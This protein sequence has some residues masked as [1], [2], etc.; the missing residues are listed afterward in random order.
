[1]PDAGGAGWL[2][3]A[4]KAMKAFFRYMKLSQDCRCGSGRPYRACC[5][6]EELIGLV[7]AMVVLALMLSLPSEG[8]PSRII[9]S[10]V[11]LVSWICVFAMLLEWILRWRAR[12]RKDEGRA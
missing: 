11:G 12:K 9:R 2:R 3:C 8:W 4:V 5:F 1:M 10:I 7:I 6:R